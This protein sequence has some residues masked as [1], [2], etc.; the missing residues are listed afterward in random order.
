MKKRI[1][2][3]PGMKCRIAPGSGIDSGAVVSIEFN[4]VIRID[5]NGIPRNV[6]GAYKPVN[7][8]TELA[9]KREDGTFGTM[10]KNRLVPIE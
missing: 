7:W 2:Y 9:F 1:L 10:F 6:A 4:D 3:R 5:S 8:A